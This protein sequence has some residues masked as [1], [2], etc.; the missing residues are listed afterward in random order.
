MKPPAYNR[1]AHIFSH[2]FAGGY[3]A[4]Y[5][6]YLWAEVLA[7]DAFSIFIRDG[8]FDQAAGER[9]KNTVLGLGGSEE[10]DVVFEKF[11]GRQPDSDA[12]LAAYGFGD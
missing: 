3:A 7:R 1:F 12:L 4:G 9:F 2:I 8:L 10:P 5:Y 6:S 11:M